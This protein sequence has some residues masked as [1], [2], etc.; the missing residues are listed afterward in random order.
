VTGHH[1]YVYL[2]IRRVTCI[3]NGG[4]FPETLRPDEL[5]RHDSKRAGVGWFEMT[6]AMQRPLP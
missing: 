2:D 3:D 1:R 4:L 6:E 5:W